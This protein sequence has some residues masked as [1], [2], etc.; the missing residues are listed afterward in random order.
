MRKGNRMR[1]VQR[2]VGNKDGIKNEG[3]REKK[4]MTHE[5]LLLF[6]LSSLTPANER[7]KGLFPPISKAAEIN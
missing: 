1:K 2:R 7:T 3:A 6:R 5:W 4:F